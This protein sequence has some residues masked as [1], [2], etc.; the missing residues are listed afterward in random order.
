LDSA[1]R[2]KG[3]YLPDFYL[4]K[5]MILFQ[6]QDC[7]ISEI[8]EFYLKSFISEGVLSPCNAQF[9]V[10]RVSMQKN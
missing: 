6:N 2:A 5:E 1:R 3:E 9:V 4:R 7:L 10:E 8:K